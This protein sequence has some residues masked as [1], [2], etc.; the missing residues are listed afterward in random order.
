MDRA[1][2]HSFILQQV[3]YRNVNSIPDFGCLCYTLILQS[4][5]I[6]LRSIHIEVDSSGAVH[7]SRFFTNQEERASTPTPCSENPKSEDGSGH[8]WQE[9][10]YITFHGFDSI[11]ERSKQSNKFDVI[12][13]TT[14]YIGR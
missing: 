14:C 11:F 8:G 7:I 2:R 13:L 4:A 12:A 3:S 5:D 9:C 10:R 1:S 6:K